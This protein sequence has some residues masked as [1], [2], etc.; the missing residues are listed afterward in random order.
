MPTAQD[1]IIYVSTYTK[2][3]TVGAIYE[4]PLPENKAFAYCL[5]KS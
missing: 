3:H 1:W 5:R 4:L 2:A